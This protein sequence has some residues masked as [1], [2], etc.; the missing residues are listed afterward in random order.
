MS[1]VLGSSAAGK[2]RGEHSHER[3]CSSLF[4]PGSTA[5]LLL[6]T[7]AL[8]LRAVFQL[9][10]G[11]V[12]AWG[13]GESHTMRAMEKMTKNHGTLVSHLTK[14]PHEMSGYFNTGH[15]ASETKTNLEEGKL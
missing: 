9:C 10:V 4:S 1:E 5:P 11:L 15:L 12:Q 14:G 8:R 2:G 13:C 6:I 3:E 7:A